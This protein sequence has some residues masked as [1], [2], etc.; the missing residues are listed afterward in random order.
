MRAAVV[1]GLV[2]SMVAASSADAAIT[3]IA[4]A[5]LGGAS[6]LSGLSGS[7]ENGMAKN[8]LG[9]IGSGLAYAGGSTFL[10]VPDRGPN[11]TAYNPG[12]DNTTSYISRFH[13]IDMALTASAAGDPLPFSLTPTLTDTT[14]LYSTAPLAYGAG[15]GLGLPSGAP[16][17]NTAGVNYFT[18][19]SDN[20]GVAGLAD[21]RFDP[22]AIR[23]S[24]DGK[25]VFISDEYGPYVRQFDR[26]SGEL[27]RTFD[28]PAN[29]AIGA[30]SRPKRAS[31]RP[32][33]R[34]APPTRAWKAWRS[35]RT[36]RPWWA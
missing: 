32:T 20:Y 18:G 4:K 27:V 34:A 9:G 15:A 19:R 31:W 24:N 29:L 10:A 16:S 6:D 2:A 26:A 11:A 30:P 33:P 23:V 35:R 3:L 7:L 1:L 13:T 36:A 25:S 28:L 5:T 8:T 17:E 12:V 22:E 14:L 21:G